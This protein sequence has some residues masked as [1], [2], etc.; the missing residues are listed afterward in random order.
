MK[1]R[2]AC[3]LAVLLAVATAAGS[4]GAKVRNVTDP[5]APRSLPD[6][7]PVSVGWTDPAQFSEIRYS[8][9]P[10]EARRGDWV[11]DLAGYLRERAQARLPA[12]ERLE[13]TITDIQRAGN[14]EPERGIRFDDVRVMRDLYPPRLTL[15]LKRTGAD[16]QVIAEGER[17]LSDPGFLRGAGV[18]NSS[19]PLRY[20]KRMI[21]RW[22]V[23]EFPAPGR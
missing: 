8:H 6:A 13:L 4:A 10:S 11:E 17:K 1:L 12:G 21:D 9:N 7:G 15:T 23:K 18:G 22:L 20:E 16:G 19:D 3:T 5:D 2:N 14:Y